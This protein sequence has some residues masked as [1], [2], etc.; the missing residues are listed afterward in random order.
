MEVAINNAMNNVGFREIALQVAY[1]ARANS[2]D[3]LLNEV[4]DITLV[5]N[6]SMNEIPENTE[7][8][9]H[10]ISAF[11]R[12]IDSMKH[13]SFVMFNDLMQAELQQLGINIPYYLEYIDSKND[14]VIGRLSVPSVS[15]GKNDYKVYSLP[16]SAQ[17][18]EAYHLYLYR[19]QWY[20]FKDMAGLVIVSLLMI[21]LLILSYIY[22]V[23]IIRR[24][25]T[26]DEIKSDFVNNM[27]H[28]LKTPLSTSYAA[29]DALQNFGIADDLIK[30][31]EYLNITKNQLI[32]LNHLVEQILTSSVEERKNTLLK[33]EKIS[34]YELF[35]SLI[36][37]F[38]INASKTI[39]FKFDVQPTDLSIL[40]DK[41]HFT[42]IISNLIENAIKY[43]YESVE[44]ALSAHMSK[45]VVKISVSDNGIGIAKEAVD[46]IFDK[47]YRIPAGNLHNV[48]GYGLGLFY[49]KTIVEQHGWTITVKSVKGKG[50]C[51][52]IK[53]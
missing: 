42:N 16:L 38:N 32:R 47:F 15:S 10:T 26:I 11:R 45:G 21:L 28:E 18:Q 23:K 35:E 9:K 46:K 6:N 17:K 25:K 1:S 19:P 2:S 52:E 33:L 24:Q 13:A 22:L 50:S 3:S 30:R 41:V 51:F 8:H 27:T 7:S 40:A 44:I 4:M 43:S 36:N 29:I 53:Y 48:K 49:V 20:I 5:V 31:N 12:S 34:V 14:S 39:D 37:Q